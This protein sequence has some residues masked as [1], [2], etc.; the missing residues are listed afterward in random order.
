MIRYKVNISDELKKRGLLWVD[1][2][3][4]GLG[5]GTLTRIRRGHP[6]DANTLDTLCRVLKVQPSRLI[7]WTPDPLPDSSK[8]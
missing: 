3:K 2:R 7:E 4:A 8:T 6:P 1:L 5:E